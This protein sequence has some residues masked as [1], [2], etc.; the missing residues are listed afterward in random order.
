LEDFICLDA[1]IEFQAAE[2]RCKTTDSQVETNEHKFGLTDVLVQMD[3][4][5]VQTNDHACEGS[6]ER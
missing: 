2:S 3:D 5:I 1:E 4:P 6:S